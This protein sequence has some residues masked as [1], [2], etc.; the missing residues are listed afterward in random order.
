MNKYIYTAALLGA[1]TLASCQ[2][3]ETT[4]GFNSDPDAVKITA[5]VGNSIFGRS[6]PTGDVDAQKRFNNGDQIGVSADAQ[7]AVVYTFDGSKWT[8]AKDT[9]LR[10]ESAT[11]NFSAYY[12][13]T[14]GTDAQ[15]FTLPTEQDDPT[16][17][18]AADYM[19]AAPV[20]KNKADGAVSL[21]LSRRTARIIVKIA[22]FNSQYTD[23][24]KYVKAM[25]LCSF[26]DA[27]KNGVVTTPRNPVVIAPYCGN[28]TQVTGGYGVGT[29]FTALL[30]PDA[31]HYDT[32]FIVLQDGIGTVLTVK[33]I[34]AHEAG[35]SYT[36]NVRVGKDK[37]EITGVTVEDWQTGEP[38]ADGE[39]EQ[40]PYFA[41]NFEKYL[42]DNLHIPVNAKGKIDPK[43]PET[44]TALEAITEL[45]LNKQYVGDL[46]GIEFLTNL[47][48]LICDSNQLTS[49][50]L[51]KNIK[52]TALYCYNNQLTSLDLAK[53]IELTMLS[54]N[55]NK[56]TS[57]DLAENIE[58]T[59][60]ICNNNKLTALN[61]SENK[62][63]RILYC[64]N[65][66]L[67][68]L[69]LA[70]N[71][72]LELLSCNE[73][74]LSSLDLSKN[75]NL[76]ILICYNNQLSSLDLSEN[77][78]LMDLKCGANRLTSLDPAENTKL[79]ALEC[80]NN[81]LTS[82]DLSVN[83]KLK[84]LDCNNNQLTSLDPSKNIELK[85]L[86]CA[87]NRLSTLDIRPLLSLNDIDCRYQTSDGTTPQQLKL[88]LTSAQDAKFTN[89]GST[90]DKVVTE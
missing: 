67:A 6:N 64:R 48:K 49:L 61:L 62:E 10:W 65:N 88:T 45:N 26:V 8:P 70:E 77:I 78:E 83:T 73:N 60:L 4:S 1:I 82:L 75:T 87:N 24:Q 2:K 46:S 59:G 80:N 41:E 15:N 29:T 3:D 85:N 33:G 81:Q 90:V 16:K 76:Q 66:Q 5:S 79:E 55:N 23:E 21:G 31:A 84:I 20:S 11:M 72:K 38:I 34:P 18:A 74:Q 35:K 12:P 51:S 43:N 13:V 57:L 7:T 44:K 56:L 58:L 42:I 47:T 71:T 40:E 30:L 28:E 52:L 36:Y 50:D 86:Y 54:C 39:T 9:Y 68:L 27:Y 32:D 19:T 53:N 17:I 37:V 89:L 25:S 63:L 69:D 14:T 22:G